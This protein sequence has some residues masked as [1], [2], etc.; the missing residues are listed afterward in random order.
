MFGDY[1]AQRH[2][3]ELTIHLPTRQWYTYDLQY[4]GLDYPPLTAYASWLCGIVGSW[5]DPSWVAL[6]DSRGVETPGSK[7]FMRSSVLALDTLIYVPALFMFTRVWQ[8]TRSSRTQNLALLLLLFQPALTIIDFGHFQYNS[9]MLGFTL[10]SMNF[11]AIGQEL[12]GAVF[13]VLSLGFKQ[14]ALYYAPAIGTYLLAKCL[15]LGPTEGTKLFIRLGIVTSASFVIL[16]LPWLPPFAP[17]R[18]ILNPI[19]RIFPFNRGLFEDKVA[20]FWCAT[21]VVL[22]WR[23]WATQSVLVKL[24]TALTALGFL[25]AVATLLFSGYRLRVWS[26]TEA[27][28]ESDKKADKK[29]DDKAPVTPAIPAAPTPIL[30]LLPY[31]LLTSSLSFFLFSFQVHEKTILVPLLPM[32]LLL[33]GSSPDEQT[34]ELGMLMNN[35]AMFSMWP[36]LKRDGQGIQYVALLILWNK[37]IG[38]NPFRAARSSYLKLLSLAVYA[39]CFAVHLAELFISPPARLPDIFP[40]LN[41]LIS[42]P[43]FAL[44][45]LWSIKRGVEVSWAIGGLGSRSK[46]PASSHKRPLPASASSLPLPAD[47]Q[48]EQHWSPDGATALR[49][50]GLRTMSLGY[51]QAR[52]RKALGRSGSVD[53]H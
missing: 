37:L 4:W 44:V 30:P 31:A 15:Y 8:G 51:A 50:G 9:V 22:K 40:V 39:A 3:M 16:F 14:M 12:V 20:N 21:N 52:Q 18:A 19:T 42:T 29:D 26:T 6:D 17:L 32:T 2:W 47:R 13:F 33:S 5:I 49:A 35:V 48:S 10:F 45:W 53:I 27:P 34:F 24:S 46:A 7:V 25:P 43:V 23:L 1:E 38:Y 41:V 11:F 28:A 36:L